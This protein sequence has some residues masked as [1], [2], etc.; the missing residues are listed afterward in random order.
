MW[1]FI[2]AHYLLYN[3]E[4]VHHLEARIVRSLSGISGVWDHVLQCRAAKEKVN[5]VAALLTL[6]MAVNHNLK[7]IRHH[8]QHKVLSLYPMFCF[9]LFD[10]F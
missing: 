6:V 5:T 4:F 7:P 8:G 2:T 1:K 9:D 3:L 10:L